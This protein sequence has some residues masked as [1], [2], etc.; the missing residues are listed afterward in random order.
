MD[1]SSGAVAMAGRGYSPFSRPAA[2][3]FYMQHKKCAVTLEPVNISSIADISDMA[4]TAEIFGWP[5]KTAL[6]VALQLRGAGVDARAARL[7]FY[8]SLRRVQ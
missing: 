5:P 3:V 1:L 6:I 8:D 7:I 2:L 4:V